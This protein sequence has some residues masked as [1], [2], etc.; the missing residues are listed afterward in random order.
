MFMSHLDNAQYSKETVFTQQRLLQITPADILRWMN[1][2][3]FGVENPPLSPRA[4][5]S[6]TP[7]TLGVLWQEWTDGIGGRKAAR[8]FT[9]EERGK[10]K[11][12]YHRRKIVWDR[13]RLLVNAGHTA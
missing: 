12:K 13:I 3:T 2:R 7:R 1:K 11:H 8:L 5:L 6:P 4:E 9:R 10:C